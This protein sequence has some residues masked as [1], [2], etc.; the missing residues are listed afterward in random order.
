VTGTVPIVGTGAGGGSGTRRASREGKARSHAE[1]SGE[2]R[3][4]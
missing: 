2:G 4:R 1:T 3:C